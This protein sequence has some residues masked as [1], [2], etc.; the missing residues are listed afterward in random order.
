M[1]QLFKSTFIISLC[2]LSSRIL[3]Y[4]RDMLMAKKLGTGM[5]NEAFLAAFRLTTMFR[6]IFA[7]G[8][9][10]LVFVPEFS[11][12]LKLNGKYKAVKFASK[13]YS[14]LV[15]ALIVFCVMI[16]IFMPSVI[17]HLVAGFKHNI[18]IYNLTVVL[19]RIIFP[20]LFCVS[21]SAFYGGMLNSFNKFFPFA[22][23]PAILN[24]AAIGFLL[25]ANKF[26]S[27]SLHNK[28]LKN[29]FYGKSQMQLQ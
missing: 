26:D 27:S 12:E 5:I 15:F 18:K 11:K 14:L 25:F 2:T 20:Y 23:A 8:A 7:E 10:N 1:G 24:I 16:V 21:L 3:G 9:L 19:G 28:V 6:N 17:R 13:V 4:S 29:I 22:I